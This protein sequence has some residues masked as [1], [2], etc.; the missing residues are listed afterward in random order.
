MTNGTKKSSG[1]KAANGTKSNGSKVPK[2]KRSPKSK[3]SKET[4]PGSD[5]PGTFTDMSADH[6]SNGNSGSPVTGDE[7]VPDFVDVADSSSSPES[8]VPVQVHPSPR[9][10]APISFST[11][12]PEDGGSTGRADHTPKSFV[13]TNLASVILGLVAVCLAVALVVTMLQLG[14]RNSQLAAKNSLE[15]ARTTALAAARTYSVELASYNYQHL[16]QNFAAIEAVSTSSWR[17]TYS[18]T[19]SALKSILFKYNSSAQATLL[20]A[21]L[22]YATTTRAVAVVFLEQAITNV[23]QKTPTSSR[24]Q[25]QMTLDYSNGRWL[26]DDV[27]V[28]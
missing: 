4:R 5:A 9:P 6:A 26:I 17:Q 8:L 21:G 23:G 2:E 13:R 27:T 14:N 11:T 20:S 18:Q 3:A 24:S 12:M 1:G 19:T 28:F 15:T 25:I 7:R 10:A 16:D 22:V